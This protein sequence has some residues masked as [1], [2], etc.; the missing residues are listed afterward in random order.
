[1]PFVWPAGLAGS[2]SATRC[3]ALLSCLG[4]ARLKRKTLDG[5]IA[6]PKFLQSGESRMP[7]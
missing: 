1:M 3:V 2:C 7:R 4:T 6:G 5:S